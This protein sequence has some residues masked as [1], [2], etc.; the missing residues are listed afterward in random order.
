MHIYFITGCDCLLKV[1]L[2]LMYL[3][4]RPHSACSPQTCHSYGVFPQGPG[5][6]EGYGLSWPQWWKRDV[7]I[8]KEENTNMRNQTHGGPFT[9]ELQM[10]NVINC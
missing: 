10:L 3:P 2:A 9:D 1:V 4:D 7:C 8:L 5:V 6:Y